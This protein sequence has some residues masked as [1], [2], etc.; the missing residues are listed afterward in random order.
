VRTVLSLSHWDRLELLE[1][2][3]EANLDSVLS[4]PSIASL[5]LAVHRIYEYRNDYLHDPRLSEGEVRLP[6]ENERRI[7]EWIA[8]LTE[9]RT[10]SSWSVILVRLVHANTQVRDFLKSSVTACSEH[11]TAPPTQDPSL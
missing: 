1:R 8:F 2:L 4:S 6:I 11:F 9:N 7:K 10:P 5:V 3:I